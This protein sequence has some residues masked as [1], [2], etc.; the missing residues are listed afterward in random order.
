MIYKCDICCK[1]FLQKFNYE[2]HL[3]RK[4]PCKTKI[5]DNKDLNNKIKNITTK[6]ESECNPESSVC[7]PVSSVCNII[8]NSVILSNENKYICL[9]CHKIFKYRQGLCKHKKTHNNYEEEIKKIKNINYDT[10]KNICDDIKNE[11]NIVPIV[12]KMVPNVAKMLPNV[13]K[14]DTQCNPV[15]NN[16]YECLICYKKYSDRSSFYKHKKNKHI[17]YEEELKKIDTN[18]KNDENIIL[19]KNQIE[20][21]KQTNDEY[22][23][24]IQNHKSKKSEKT[25]KLEIIKNIDTLNNNTTNNNSNNTQNNTINNI[26]NNYVVNFGEE[27]ISKLTIDN[28][29]EIFNSGKQLFPT[30]ISKIYLNEKIP[31]NNCICITNLRSNDMLITENGEL[32]VVNKKKT[33]EEILSNMSNYAKKMFEEINNPKEELVT[34]NINQINDIIKRPKKNKREISFTEEQQKRI[35]NEIMFVYNY[36]PTG[37]DDAEDAIKL[38]PNNVKRYTEIRKDSEVKI[39]NYKNKNLSKLTN[40]K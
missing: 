17:N 24:I 35:N 13:A 39:Y 16:S 32:V 37:E 21:L 1:T 20:E 19:L 34:F 28:K 27:D 6:T 12:A 10:N 3:K 4:I 25:K 29:R 2:R 5:I 26:T 18:K 23:N 31:E 9:V 36:D 11:N 22:K 8:N 30:L 14:M 38:T 40:K 33:M 7:N 15:I